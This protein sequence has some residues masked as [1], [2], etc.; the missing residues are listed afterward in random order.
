M[1]KYMKDFNG[2]K[3]FSL[4]YDK[5][6]LRDMIIELQER[7][8]KTIKYCKESNLTLKSHYFMDVIKL[9]EGEEIEDMVSDK[10]C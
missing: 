8:N 1:S 2:E 6:T 7:I 4:E 5:E 10:E 9:L 3:V